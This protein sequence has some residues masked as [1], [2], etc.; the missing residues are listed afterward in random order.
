MTDEEFWTELRKMVKQEVAAYF[1]TVP[2][3]QEPEELLGTAALCK[4]L[5]ISKQTLYNL[6]YVNQ[7]D[8]TATNK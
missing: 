5:G 3:L 2:S 6:R 4:E 8:I 1:S 7:Q